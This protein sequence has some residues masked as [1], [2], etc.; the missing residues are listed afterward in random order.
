MTPLVLQYGLNDAAVNND[1]SLA[2]AELADLPQTPMIWKDIPHLRKAETF[3]NG[4][5]V[6][7]SS[8]A[9]PSIA[10]FTLAQHGSFLSPSALANYDYWLET[11]RD[12]GQ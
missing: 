8:F 6:V 11:I 2:L 9:L 7:Q 1:A 10:P 3:E 12:A 5:A 4:F